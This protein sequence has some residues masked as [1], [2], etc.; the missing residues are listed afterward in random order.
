MAQIILEDMP[1]EKRIKYLEAWHKR[2]EQEKA[3]KERLSNTE[4]ARYR[5]E[6]TAVI[7]TNGLIVSHA[8]TKREFLVS[9]LIRHNDVFVEVEMID[10]IISIKPKHLLEVAQLFTEIDK[11]KCSKVI[12]E[13]DKRTGKIAKINNHQY[14]IDKW[15][16][17]RNDLY[18]KFNFLRTEVNQNKRDNFITAI[19]NMIVN[20][21]ILI[22]DL[23]TK[24][25][26]DL[27][28]DKYLVTKE[29]L[30]DPY[31]REFN[32]QLFEGVKIELS[33]KQD[34]LQETHDGFK[35]KKTG[36]IKK[37][38]LDISAIESIYNEKYKPNIHYKF[39][40]YDFIV[41]DNTVMS[42]GNNYWIE[43]SDISIIERVKNNIDILVDY[44]LK[45]IE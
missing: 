14:I 35:V 28:F 34:I 20:Q 18:N 24:L 5:C 30:F 10:N 27:F 37:D 15:H 25:F 21:K 6:Q 12:V 42:T 45:K 32:S 2:K 26:F 13:V 8:D 1:Y 3:D 39:S 29:N 44:K 36:K 31:K 17:Y 16:E 33:F 41:I 40:E 23:N 19:D 38:K 43:Q 22:E 4:Q 7:K 11:V 9:K